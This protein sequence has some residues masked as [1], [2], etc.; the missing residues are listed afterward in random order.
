MYKVV[1]YVPIANADEL[2]RAIGDSGGGK[3]GNYSRC[4]FSSRGTGRFTPEYGSSPT[5][6]EIGKEEEVGEERIEFAC[7]ESLLKSVLAAIRK[8]HPYEE[9]A[10]DAWP[11]VVLP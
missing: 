5:V 6:G 3:V 8:A 4:S 1:V 11:L 2:R 10:I 9:P 7:E